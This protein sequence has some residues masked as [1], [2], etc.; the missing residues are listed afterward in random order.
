MKVNAL[1]RENL[2]ALVGERGGLTDLSNKLGYRN[3]S[4]LSQMIGPNPSRE[5]TEK[6]ARKIEQTLRLE[7]GALDRPVAYAKAPAGAEGTAQ[8]VADALRL[9]GA[10]CEAE[11]ANIGP[12]KLAE[13]AALVI[14]DGVPARPERVRRLVGLLK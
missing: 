11:G 9:V 6:T 4:F 14:E 2:R 3:P 1:R 10:V 12:A 7:A 13:L 5:I 8:M